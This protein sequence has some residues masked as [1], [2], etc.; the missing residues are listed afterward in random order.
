[1]I[2]TA[3]QKEAFAD[4]IQRITAGQQFE[5]ADLVGY[6]TQV[7]M[8]ARNKLKPKKAPRT[9][10]DKVMIGVAFTCGIA[11]VALAQTTY[12]ILSKLPGLP[13]VVYKSEGKAVVLLAMIV[14]ICLILLFQLF[15]RGRIQA[16]VLG[17]LLMYF[18]NSML[19]SPDV[20]AQF[21][22]QPAGTTAGN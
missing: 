7:A 17:C 3:T 10:R 14:S 8:A 20:A 13:E 9:L 16:L 15:T 18:G 1:M 19:Q 6:Q 21:T 11:A 4:R 5:H 2:S 12:Q 22:P